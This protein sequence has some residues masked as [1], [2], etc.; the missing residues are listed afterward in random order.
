MLAQRRFRQLISE[1]CKVGPFDQLRFLI[2]INRFAH[3]RKR[4]AR[5]VQQNNAAP[6]SRVLELKLK[7]R[8]AVVLLFPT[9]DCVRRLVNIERA[10]RYIYTQHTIANTAHLEREKN[11]V[12]FFIALTRAWRVTATA[13]SIFVA[14]TTPECLYYSVFLFPP[15]RT[16][17][18]HPRN[19]PTPRGRD[20]SYGWVLFKLPELSHCP[21]SPACEERLPS[22]QHRHIEHALRPLSISYPSAVQRDPAGLPQSSDKKLTRIT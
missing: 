16:L 12:S 6:A 11:P 5:P 20:F 18:R 15:E 4:S 2:F 3:N 13:S 7:V 9:L 8:P 10:H 1:A 19:P 21:I 14:L 22:N 17:P